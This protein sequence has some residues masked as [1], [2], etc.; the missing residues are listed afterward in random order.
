VQSP[1]S[2]RVGFASIRRRRFEA[3]H[4]REPSAKGTKNRGVTKTGRTEV[5]PLPKAEPGADRRQQYRAYWQTRLLPVLR[6]EWQ[7]TEAIAAA[8]DAKHQTVLGQLGELVKQGLVE[9]RLVRVPDPTGKSALK[10]RRVVRRIQAQ[11]RL[12]QDRQ[13]IMSRPYV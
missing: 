13:V 9:R 6:M 7:S 10:R 11:F 2:Y 8:V 5:A 1:P 3:C 4:L 12:P